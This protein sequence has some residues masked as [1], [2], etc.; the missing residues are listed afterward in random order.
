MCVFPSAWT[1]QGL[2]AAKMSSPLRA[3]AGT[4]C[5]AVGCDPLPSLPPFS[6]GLLPFRFPEMALKVALCRAVDLSLCRGLEPSSSCPLPSLTAQVALTWGPA[7]SPLPP[8]PPVCG[9]YG[10]NSSPLTPRQLGLDAGQGPMDPAG[11]GPRGWDREDISPN[12]F[13]RT[14]GR[15]LQFQSAASLYLSGASPWFPAAASPPLTSCQ[16]PRVTGIRTLT[17]ARACV[18]VCPHP[19]A[20]TW[21]GASEPGG[22]VKAATPELTSC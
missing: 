8:P 9:D 13:T 12:L 4:F 21:R 1:V 19:R 17:S 18:S 22:A 14:Q 2:P 11:S 5:W 20:C 3:A 15:Y 16:Q 7:R 6:L 10:A